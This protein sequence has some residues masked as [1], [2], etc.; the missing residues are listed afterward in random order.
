MSKN[1]GL[2]VI[3]VGC[4]KVGL[5]LVEQLSRE[6]HDITVI[7]KDRELVESISGTYDVM[8]VVGNG[9]S[10]SI[11][12]EAGIENTDLIIA[13]TE[14]DELNLLCCTV[15]KRVANC[16]AIAR[17]RTPDYSHDVS[18]LQERLGL[19]MIFNPELESAKEAARM[20][21]LPTALEVASFAH[22]QAELI[23]FKI[24]KDNKLDGMKLW[25]MSK[26][27]PAD[28]E[29]NVVICAVERGE[30][31]H[32]PSGNFRLQCG[33]VVSFVSTRRIARKFLRSIGFKTRQ[34]RSTMIVG[35]GRSSYYLAQELLQMGIAVKIIEKNRARCEELC[36]L[37]P[38]ATIINGDG[39]DEAFLREE[40]IEYAESF[41]A[42][43][44]IDEENILLTI[45]ARNVSNA[46]VITKINRVTFRSAINTLDLGSVIYPRYITSEAIVAYARAKHNSMNSNV[47]T[48]NYLCDNRVE[49]V[50]IRVNEASAVTGTM[51]KEL[52]PRMKKDIL[53]ASINRKGKI[54]IPSGMDTIE[55]EDSVMVVTSHSGFS[56][57]RDILA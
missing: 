56:D 26:S 35:G 1:K 44:G 4:G 33:D 27:I 16:S 18:Y 15:A 2:S 51:L 6:G 43:T 52:K 20:L 39:S 17:V 45:H 10:Y 32:I 31:V 37:L 38:N 9:A 19:A 42:L 40:G 54:L 30:E 55:P 50:E 13:V 7:D 8:G 36:E 28:I 46:K 22:G 24:P 57:I 41:V 5:T 49:A 34:V 48:L 53:I 3:I 25:D 12:K 14:S 21:S 29:T 47:E 11:Q 23:N